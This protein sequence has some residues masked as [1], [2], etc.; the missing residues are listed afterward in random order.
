MTPRDVG[1]ILLTGATGLIGGRIAA[2]LLAADPR[3]RLHALV[4]RPAAAAR[5]AA[6]AGSWAGRLVPVIG[7]IATPGLGL[8]PAVRR[9]LARAVRVVV[10][11]AGDVTFSRPLEEARAT[12]TA[13]TGHVLDLFAGRGLDRFVYLSSAYAAGR[14]TGL[15]PEAPLDGH[16]GFVNGYEQSKL[17][18]ELLVRAAGVPAVVLRPSA[19]VCDDRSGA[20]TQFNSVHRALRVLRAGLVALMP[21][22]PDTPIDTVTTDYVAAGAIAIGFADAA[23]GGTFHLCAGRR[24][25]TLGELVERSMAAWRRDPEW[26][27]RGVVPP[28]CVDPDIYRLFES[29]V[30]ETGDLRLAAVLRSLAHFVPQLALPKRFDTARADALLG[31]AAP[32]PAEYWDAMLVWLG[33]TR[34]GAAA[35]RVA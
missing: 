34:W 8:D 16:E 19:L 12:N 29:S 26:R 21:G 24:A 33:R 11:C 9:R 6:R 23:A 27:A 32:A 22:R 1:P 30:D 25:I 35:R 5:L 4:R 10:H 7:D 2:R 14:R 20:V 13:G 3:I 18:A 28:A 17:E 31:D 15:I